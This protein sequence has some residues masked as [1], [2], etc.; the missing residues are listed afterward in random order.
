[1]AKVTQ[2]KGLQSTA[3]VTRTVEVD[4]NVLTSKLVSGGSAYEEALKKQQEQKQAEK[5]KKETVVVNSNT[6]EAKNVFTQMEKESLSNNNL[7]PSAA[8]RQKKSKKNVE[9]DRDEKTETNAS[10]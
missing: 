10:T 5:K 1:S 8:K 2:F 3:K 7:R 4:E 9:S 6:L